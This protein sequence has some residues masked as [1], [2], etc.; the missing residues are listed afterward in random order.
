VHRAASTLSRLANSSDRPAGSQARTARESA[1]V[2]WLA[3]VA[4]AG[5]ALFVAAWLVAG[6]LEPHYSHDRQFVSELAAMNAHHRWIVSAGLVAWGGSFFAIALALRKAL[7]RRRWALLPPALFV[8]IGM[9]TAASALLPLDCMASVNPV[10]ARHEEAWELSWTHSGHILAAWIGMTLIAATP[11]S[12]ALALAP[13]RL[14]RVALALGIAGLAL[15][16]LL[17]SPL[18]FD[19]GRDIHAGMYQRVGL[20]IVHGWVCLI[21]ASLF[22]VAEV[23]PE[24]LGR[25]G[26][27]SGV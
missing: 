12:L 9:L 5:Q 10:C 24:R 7:P 16:L 11:F 27:S 6:A 25:S 17:L 23:G 19:A 18:L 20:A 2:K 14:S 13:G 4:V 21:A 8:A 22:L 1:R 26:S 3:L 15:A